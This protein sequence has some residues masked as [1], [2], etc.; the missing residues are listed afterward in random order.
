MGREVAT[1]VQNY[2]EEL[3]SEDTGTRAVH[4]ISHEAQ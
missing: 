3:H 2:P 4:L 1:A